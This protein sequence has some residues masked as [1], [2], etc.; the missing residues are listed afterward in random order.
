MWECRVCSSTSLN[1]VTILTAG[2]CWRKGN[3]VSVYNSMRPSSTNLTGRRACMKDVNSLCIQSSVLIRALCKRHTEIQ[4]RRHA[5]ISDLWLQI[6][7]WFEPVV[8]VYTGNFRSVCPWL[9]ASKETSTEMSS[10]VHLKTEQL[11][12]KHER[13]TWTPLSCCQ[14]WKN[15][16]SCLSGRRKMQ[17]QVGLGRSVGRRRTRRSPLWGEK[18]VWWMRREPAK[19]H[20]QKGWKSDYHLERRT[21]IGGDS[22]ALRQVKYRD[23]RGVNGGLGL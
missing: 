11:P 21:C 14:P 13:N 2:L 7:F 20:W 5:L 9:P 10:P 22:L 1:S 4:Q 15:T 8:F 23:L 3:A 12:L 18:G 16:A 6:M 19:W 17:A